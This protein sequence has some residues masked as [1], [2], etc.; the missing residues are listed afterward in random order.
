MQSLLKDFPVLY[1]GRL[2]KKKK[3][4]KEKAM[5]EVNKWANKC[6]RHPKG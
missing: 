2:F 4:E 6:E 3:K 1:T 5:L